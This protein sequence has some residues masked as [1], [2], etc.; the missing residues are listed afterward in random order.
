M[1]G[2][3]FQSLQK[4]TFIRPGDE[5]FP[6]GPIVLKKCNDGDVYVISPRLL[7]VSKLKKSYPEWGDYVNSLPQTEE[8]WFIPS[9]EDIMNIFDSSRVSREFIEGRSNKQD[10]FL[11]K[12]FL[13]SDPRISR[14]E[15][16]R[17][18]YKCWSL[19]PIQYL[20]IW[21]EANVER[22]GGELL[23]NA[24]VGIDEISQ[25]YSAN[26]APIQKIKFSDLYRYL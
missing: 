10:D 17:Y 21:V 23:Y 14:Y 5:L 11:G 2:I 16:K 25:D 8:D 20:D 22:S 9:S 3:S 4:Y 18:Y 6:D 7:H 19:K 1:N 12:R 15:P 24:P 26:I 13:L